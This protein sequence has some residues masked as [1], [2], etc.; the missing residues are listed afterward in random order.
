MQLETGQWLG[1]LIRIKKAKSCPWASDENEMIKKT[2]I[3]RA[4]KSWPLTNTKRERFD[5]AIEVTQEDHEIIDVNAQEQEEIESVSIENL[6]EMIKVLERTEEQT[7]EYAARVF[8]RKIEKLSD[9]LAEEV[10]QLETIL[11]VPYNKKLEG[12]AR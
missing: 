4:Y 2:V 3:R 6:L 10:E 5:N 12:G 9:L 11:S 7:A 8:E 1:S